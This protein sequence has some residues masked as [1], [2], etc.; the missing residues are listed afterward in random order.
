[1]SILTLTFYVKGHNKKQEDSR[2]LLNQQVL[3][4]N[5]I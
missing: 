4:L 2:G 5:Y 1:M 3:R